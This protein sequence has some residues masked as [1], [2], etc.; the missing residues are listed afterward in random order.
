MEL[1]LSVSSLHLKFVVISELSFDLGIIL[2][3]LLRFNL[4]FH[5]A[6]LHQCLSF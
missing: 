3:P 4:L 2:R 6:L 5:P 1:V